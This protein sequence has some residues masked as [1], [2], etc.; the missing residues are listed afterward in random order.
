MR[1]AGRVVSVV[2]AVLPGYANVVFTLGN[3]P[4]PNEQNVQFSSGQTDT[5]ITGMTNQTGD[6]V[7]FSSTTDTLVVASSGQANVSAQDGLVNNVSIMLPG[8][9]YQGLIINPFSGSLCQCLYLRPGGRDDLLLL[10][11]GDSEWPE[12]SLSS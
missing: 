5:T 11:S 7:N 4:Q 2:V 8:R 10:L 1:L 9:T 3:N 6:I 12:F